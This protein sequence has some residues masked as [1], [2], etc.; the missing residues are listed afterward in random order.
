M[1]TNIMD[2]KAFEM[3]ELRCSVFSYK[4]M[5]Q[6][7][8][9]ICDETDGFKYVKMKRSCESRFNCTLLQLKI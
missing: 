6:L 2:S 5:N 4:M 1:E 8:A 7:H 3:V 9:G